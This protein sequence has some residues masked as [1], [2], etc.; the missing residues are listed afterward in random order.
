[1]HYNF[2]LSVAV[3]ISVC[4]SSP[5]EDAARHA[6]VANTASAFTPDDEG[7]VNTIDFYAVVCLAGN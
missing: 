7:D 3:R 2:A 6:G 1:M 4:D 5:S